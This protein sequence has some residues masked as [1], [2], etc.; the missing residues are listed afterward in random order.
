MNNE[1]YEPIIFFAPRATDEAINELS[2]AGAA[3]TKDKEDTSF[4]LSFFM[5]DEA[6]AVKT[7]ESDTEKKRKTR[8]TASTRMSLPV[9]IE[10]RKDN[11]LDMASSTEVP[12]LSTYRDT[13]AM[14]HTTIAQIDILSSEVKAD[15]DEIRSSKSLR[16]KYTYLTNLNGAQAS[17][18][19][20]KLNAIKE[21]N[22]SI[23]QAHNLDLKRAKDLKDIAAAEKNDDARMMDL[24][25]AFINAPMGMYDNKLNMPT[26][27]D[28]MLGVNDP[29]SGISGVSMN[30]NANQQGMSPE[31]LR[32]RLESNPNIEEIVVY[33]PATG[34]KWF[35]VIDKTTG[36]SVPNFPKSDPFLLEDVSIE[37]RAGIAKNRNLDR[38]WPLQVLGGV[39]MSEY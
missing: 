7:T 28:M 39:N 17:L 3:A 19:S 15:I 9:V 11:Q 32:M 30:S 21:L 31:Q 27:P 23:T 33:D 13:N 18:I 6:N 34:R 29:N 25:S 10:G 26:I 14:L 38:V 5:S 20:A 35:D 16:N 22:S 37:T 8:S 4:N 36:Q 2:N 24:Y 1:L 12:Y